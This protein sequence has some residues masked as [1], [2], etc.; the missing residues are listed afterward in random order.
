MKITADIIKSK[1]EHGSFIVL[2]AYD[3]CFARAF[4]S[5]GVDVLLVGDSVGMVCFGEKDTK[6]VTIE[7]MAYHTRG[8]S[9]GAERSLVVT[10]MP[11]GTY[12]SPESALANAKVL[13]DAGADAV[14]VEGGQGILPA[15]RALVDAGIDVVGHLGL[16][17]QTAENFKVTG[18]SDEDAEEIIRDSKA[19]QEAG[20]FALTI[21][22]VPWQLGERITDMLDIPTIGIGAGSK[23]TGQVLVCYDMLGLFKDFKPKFVRR[24]SD[25]GEYVAQAVESY[26]SAVDSGDF[27]GEAEQFSI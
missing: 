26:R 13:I 4:D 11:I 20:I 21:E 8:V 27:P 19:L 14:K 25:L 9:R 18:K 15:V 16:T 2:T 24:F 1:E 3:Y 5:A 17:P 22:C 7:H 6:S 23:C 10:D 12:D